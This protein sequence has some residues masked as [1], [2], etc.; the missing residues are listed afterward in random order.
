MTR[1]RPNASGSA[2]APA[3]ERGWFGPALALLVTVVVLALPWRAAA[4]PLPPAVVAVVDYQ[5]VLREA[6]AARSIR[7]Q[8]EARRARYQREIRELE[9]RLVERERELA[10]Q[11]G[12]L[13]PEAFAEKRRAFE[14]EAA[15]VQRLV[16]RRRREL[17]RASAEAFAVVRDTIV[18]VVSE[19]ADEKGFNLVLPSTAVLLFA[20]QLDLTEEVL[21]A[22]DRRLPDVTVPEPSADDGA[23]AR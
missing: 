20:P 14:E 12:L 2:S 22:V 10:R 3:S 5:R 6:K 23:R 11:K 7:N 13:S 9:R 4:E 1:T 17:D 8:L 15:R 19:M 16:Q 21:A 18:Q